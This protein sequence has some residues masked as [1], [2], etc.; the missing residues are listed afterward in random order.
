[1]LLSYFPNSN[2]D[3]A[4]PVFIVQGNSTYLKN[5]T[6]NQKLPTV[7]PVYL[8]GVA[9][10][11]LGTFTLNQGNISIQ[12][13]GAGTI[14]LVSIDAAAIVQ[15]CSICSTFTQVRDDSDLSN[16]MLNG[17]WSNVSRMIS[18]NDDV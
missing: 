3:K 8:N 13:S 14:G 17:S 18:M 5:V 9:F 6:I 1:V 15:N 7:N 4:V 2:R 12:V 11:S 16:V 10:T